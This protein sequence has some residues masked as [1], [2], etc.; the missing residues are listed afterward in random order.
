MQTINRML[1][2]SGGSAVWVDEWGK[3][4]EPP[5]LVVGIASRLVMDVRGETANEETGKVLPYPME[6]LTAASY[7][8]AIDADFLSTTD[9][10]ILKLDAGLI[11]IYVYSE[12]YR[13]SKR[14]QKIEFL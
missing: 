11:G 3:G 13:E 8:M 7:Y 10:L 9:P 14:G 2:V 12:T 1:M 5:E 6:E 4:M